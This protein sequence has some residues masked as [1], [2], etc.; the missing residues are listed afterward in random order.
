MSD[1]DINYCSNIGQITVT[2]YEDTEIVKGGVCGYNEDNITNCYFLQ[3][4]DINQDINGVGNDENHTGATPKNEEEYKSADDSGVLALLNKEQTIVPFVQGSDGFPLPKLSVIAV[5]LNK[6]ELTLIA[7]KSETLEATVIPEFAYDKNLEW[8]S[9]DENVAT[10]DE[11]GKI[12][13]LNAGMATITVKS[14]DGSDVSAACEVT[15]KGKI[16]AEAD[17]AEGGTVEGIGD[18]AKGEKVTLT[19]IANR[20]YR[21]ANW[22]EGETVVSTEEEYSF[23]VDCNRHLTANFKKISGTVPQKTLTFEVG[24]GSEIDAVTENYGKTIVLADYTPKR[25]GYEF[26]GWYKD[27]ALSEKIEYAVLDNDMTV[28]AKWQKI[29][30]AVDYDTLIVLTINDKTAVVNG[31]AV[32]TDVAPLIVNGRTYTPARFV[33]ES[34]GAKVVW[35]EKARTVTITKD[36]VKI[37]L[38]IDS[39]TAYVNGEAVKM[40]ASAF[41]ADGRTY[42][43]ARFVAESLGAQVEWDED[44]RTVTIWQ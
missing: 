18:Y 14:K 41:I 13:A 22:T 15:V 21:F 33:A 28:Y 3:T 44:A 10:V 30:E 35:D 26:L 25:D 2:N 5:N 27:K 8:E 36:D 16:T 32:T 19:A 12:T 9:S 37:I 6:T 34:L 42:T 4:D 43:P 20:G 24:G 1:G 31:K 29:E 11:N 39:S 23:E 17:P 7:G 38:V 40:D